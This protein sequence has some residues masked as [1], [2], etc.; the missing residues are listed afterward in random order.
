MKNNSPKT[1]A[2]K[3][4]TTSGHDCTLIDIIFIVCLLVSKCRNGNAAA[5]VLDLKKLLKQVAAIMLDF[6]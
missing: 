1:E 5:D 6:V 4:A 3:F 2:P